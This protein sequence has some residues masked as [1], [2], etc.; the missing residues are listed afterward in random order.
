M[1]DQLVNFVIRPPRADYMPSHD[2]LER[3]F[4]LKGHRYERKDL[5]ITN[6]RGHVLQCSHYRPRPLP[7]DV[8]L[9]CVIYCHGN[10]GCRA[11]ANEAAIILLPSNITVFTLDFSGSGLSE[12]KYVS[13]GWNET[14]DLKAVVTHLRKDKQVS[15]VGL[16]GRSMGAVTSLFYGAQDPSI[17]GMVLDSPFSNLF[18]LMLELVDVYKIRLPKFTV[19]VAVQYMRRL[20]LK[21]AQFD[22]MDLDV[23]KVAQKNFV[24]VLFGHATEDLFI[25]PHHSDAI[26]KAYGGDKN[27][28]KFEGDHN[29]ARP[30]FYYDSV[31]IFFYN[32]LRPPSETY[33]E[34]VPVPDPL[35]YDVNGYVFDEDIDENMLYEIMK[36]MQAA[37]PKPDEN[38]A[39]SQAQQRV[40]GG[41][42]AKTDS[43]STEDAIN[44]SRSRWQMSRTV[45]PYDNT[46][47]VED[48]AELMKRMDQCGESASCLHTTEAEQNDACSRCVSSSVSN[49]LD[50]SWR[51][52]TGS[53]SF[54]VSP[55][56][57]DGFAHFPSTFDDEERMVME[58]IAASLEEMS[59]RSK[60]AASRS[61]GAAAPVAVTAAS[62][63]ASTSSKLET[64]GQRLRSGLFR[65]MNKRSNSSHSS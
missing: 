29:S 15:L 21:R 8:S 62:P 45:V 23:I 5:E 46:E 7:E 2:L 14:D 58:A 18:E 34:S 17:A 11:D 40:V 47:Q 56:S 33:A 3:E 6:S 63:T 52:E 22:I 50:D 42:A 36:G 57:S 13:L 54:Q 12:G 51:G 64:F 28:I 41:A 27:I 1:I 30:Q 26:F 61:Q 32:V 53:D 16:W 44:Q 35:Y 31:T 59:L 24:P 60:E 55:S 65:G 48:A 20:I 19:K 9:P 39:T 37:N 43:S 38:G 25:Q 4:V 49:G 10:S